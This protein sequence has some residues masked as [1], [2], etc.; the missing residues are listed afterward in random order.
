MSNLRLRIQFKNTVFFL[1]RR[2]WPH[3]G[4]EILSLLLSVKLL[5]SPLHSLLLPF[6]TLVRCHQPGAWGW[7]LCWGSTCFIG[8]APWGRAAEERVLRLH[9]L[10]YNSSHFTKTLSNGVLSNGAYN[11][12]DRWHFVGSQTTRVHTLVE[13]SPQA[14]EIDSTCNLC[15]ILHGAVYMFNVFLQRR[16]KGNNLTLPYK[17]IL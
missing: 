12:L 14:K 1:Q 11:N 9:T 5:P 4:L 8:H 10:R 2:L 13:C 15:T 7:A 3:Q 6:S 16:L 17:I